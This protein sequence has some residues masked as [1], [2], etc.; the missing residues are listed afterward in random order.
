MSIMASGALIG[1]D[2]AVERMRCSNNGLGGRI[3]NSGSVAGL[4]VLYDYLLITV[5]EKFFSHS[6]HTPPRPFVPDRSTPPDTTSQ[7]GL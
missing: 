1:M 6:P 3:V 2:I 7:S 5:N 4:T